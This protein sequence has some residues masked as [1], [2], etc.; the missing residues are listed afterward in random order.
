[1]VF[2]GLSRGEGV[3]TFSYRNQV[4]GQDVYDTASGLARPG[5]CRTSD[6]RC[7]DDADMLAAREAYYSLGKHLVCIKGI[8]SREARPGGKEEV[9]FGEAS[10]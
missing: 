9:T 2:E 10:H 1:M 7:T 6:Q 3:K 5:A 4:G 8:F